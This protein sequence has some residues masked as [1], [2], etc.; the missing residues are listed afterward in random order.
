MSHAPS[1]SLRA[2]AALAA[3]VLASGCA[4][5]VQ[6]TASPAVLEVRA[7]AAAKAQ[8]ACANTD[9]ASVSPAFV[10]FAFGDAKLTDPAIANLRAAGQWLACHPQ[11]PVTIAPN[12]D[13]HG[14]PDDQRQL[15]AAR[16]EAAAAYLRANGGALAVIRVLPMGED[17]KDAAPHLQVQAVGRG[18]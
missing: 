16:A 5:R 15:S 11:T 12:A 14:T 1:L 4:T 17:D 3:L 2:G 9:L 13:H 10:G 8:A 7:R 18:W 6:P